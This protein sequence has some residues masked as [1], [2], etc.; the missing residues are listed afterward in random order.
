MGEMDTPPSAKE[1]FTSSNAKKKF[2]ESFAKAI[3]VVNQYEKGKGNRVIPSHNELRYA[4][5]HLIDAVKISIE[6]GNGTDSWERAK[7]HADRANYDVS[8]FEVAS[9]ITAIRK[10]LKKYEAHAHL[11]ALTIENYY[12]H[13]GNYYKYFN[14]LS[15]IHEFDKEDEEYKAQCAQFVVQLDAFWNDI[16][17][18]KE[19]FFSAIERESREARNHKLISRFIF[20][21]IALWPIWSKCI[22][23]LYSKL[24]PLVQFVF[25]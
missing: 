21:V 18:G 19:N 1:P 8:E 23:F 13:I 25:E 22:V 5:R 17:K 2:S 15:E 12:T 11:L 14:Y 9:L 7:R 3:K 6:G 4:T 20:W 24:R 16:V 10:F